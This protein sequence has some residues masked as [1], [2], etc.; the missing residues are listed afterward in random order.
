MIKLTTKKTAD[1]VSFS[2]EQIISAK[3]YKHQKDIVN[4]VLEDDQKYT[5]KQVDDLIEKFKKGKVK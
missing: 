1:A 2:R 5:I 4:V 3:K